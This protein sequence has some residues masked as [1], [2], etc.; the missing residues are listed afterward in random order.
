[1]LKAEVAIFL[2]RAPDDFVELGVQIG[3][4]KPWYD[5]FAIEDGVED[6]AGSVTAEGL[7][8]VHGQIDGELH[9]TSLVVAKG[10]PKLKEVPPPDSQAALGQASVAVTRGQNQGAAPGQA[11]VMMNGSSG[12]VTMASNAVPIANLVN[13]LSTQLATISVALIRPARKGLST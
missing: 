10:G 2:Q 6:D 3:I 4:Q 9:G 12:L 5:G 1:M 13:Q 11:L 7:V 8:E